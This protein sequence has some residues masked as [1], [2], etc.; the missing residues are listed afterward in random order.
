MKKIFSKKLLILCFVAFSVLAVSLKV[1]AISSSRKRNNIASQSVSVSKNSP[2]VVSATYSATLGAVQTK[3]NE[4]GI[5]FTGLRVEDM[6]KSIDK[7]T[8]FL[9]NKPPTANGKFVN[10]AFMAENVS[11]QPL[12]FQANGFVLKD[13]QGRIYHPIGG[14]NCV[15][16]TS[17]DVVLDKDGVALNQNPIEGRAQLSPN[18]PCTWNLLADVPTDAKNFTLD[19][20]MNGITGYP[21]KKCPED[22]PNTDEGV[23]ERLAAMNNWTNEYYDTHPGATL[24]DWIKARGDFYKEH[25]CVKTLKDI[26]DVE[27]GTASPALAAKAKVV[28]AAVDDWAASNTEPDIK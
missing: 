9:F 2:S 25:N 12:Q 24:A 1:I 13:D 23:R 26:S 27:N 10:V 15:V 18:V 17:S 19:I 20:T 5:K 22:Y 28:N 8:G 7:S 16:A 6:G 4:L 14:Y 11:D 3:P 21:P